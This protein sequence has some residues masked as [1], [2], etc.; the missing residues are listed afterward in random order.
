[1]IIQGPPSQDSSAESESEEE[2][3][4]NGYMNI[5]EV[6][7]NETMSTFLLMGALD[8]FRKLPQ[9]E[10]FNFEVKFVDQEGRFYELAAKHS[11]MIRDL[12]GDIELTGSF[13]RKL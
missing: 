11:E 4:E 2:D 3:G 1:M 7:K 10:N 8:P 9:V 6:A 12:K 5:I 13:S